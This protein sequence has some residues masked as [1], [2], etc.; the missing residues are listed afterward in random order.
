MNELLALTSL[1]WLVALME[2][3]VDWPTHY[4]G[5]DLLVEVEGPEII[6]SVR[7]ADPDYQTTVVSASEAYC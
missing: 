1:W 2:T 6:S 4:V 3:R 5:L 7:T